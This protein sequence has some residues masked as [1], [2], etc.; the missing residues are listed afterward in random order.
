M[1]QNETNRTASK[2]A[3]LFV[4]AAAALFLAGLL[5]GHSGS[6][7][8]PL[9]PRESPACAET[10]PQ[11][12]WEENGSPDTFSA[13]LSA[14]SGD[15]LP[16]PEDGRKVAYT[17]YLSLDSQNYD[18]TRAALFSAL[19]TAGGTLNSFEEYSAEGSLRSA[20]A[21]FSVP[22]DRYRSFL[23]AAGETGRI[24]NQSEQ[25]ED[26]TESYADTEGRIRSLTA[27]RDRLL[28]LEASA[29]SLSDLLEI[30]SRLSEVQYELESTQGRMQRL[31]ARVEFCS[32]T[33]FLTEVREEI[34][35]EEPFVQ[36]ASRAF[37]SGWE[38]FCVTVRRIALLGVLYWP[39]LL[40]LLI[41]AA[42]WLFIR[43]L[44]QPLQKRSSSKGAH[45]RR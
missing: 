2:K 31:R 16:S 34:P 32:V 28:E 25:A 33:V 4:P 19:E 23:D 30:Q 12:L 7:A 41:I 14:I 45:A 1:S 15:A 40:L 43:K 36:K 24:T 44:R 38:A 42:L 22:A 17:A 21:V 39:Y 8:V 3:L 10:M 37:R 13:S 29:E 6:G 5:I 11:G 35:D 18:D 20:S 27:Q 26:V 9:S